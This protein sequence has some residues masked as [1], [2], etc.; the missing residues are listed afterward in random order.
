MSIVSVIRCTIWNDPSLSLFRSKKN[1]LQINVIAQI[2]LLLI[3]GRHTSFRSFSKPDFS[4]IELFFYPEYFIL[5]FSST[6][7][8]RSETMKFW[9]SLAEKSHFFG[10]GINTWYCLFEQ[11]LVFFQQQD[12]NSVTSDTQSTTYLGESRVTLAL[13]EPKRTPLLAIL[14]DLK[15]FSWI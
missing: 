10:F 1:C 3:L 8:E 9:F 5:V 14:H 12:W 4:S 2:A 15:D 11:I 6:A 7:L 13:F